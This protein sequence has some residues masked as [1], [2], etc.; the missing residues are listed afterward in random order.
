MGLSIEFEESRCEMRCLF[1][2][3]S[4]YQKRVCFCAPNILSS[5]EIPLNGSS[6]ALKSMA[7]ILQSQEDES[8]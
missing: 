3:F 5:D 4:G 2:K 1:G 8:K 7:Q 6:I